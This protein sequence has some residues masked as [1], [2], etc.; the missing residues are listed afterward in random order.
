MEGVR[1]GALNPK[2]GVAESRVGGLMDGLWGLG[3]I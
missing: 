3:L 2:H 1:R